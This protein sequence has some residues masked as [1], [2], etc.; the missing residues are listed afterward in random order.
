MISTSYIDQLIRDYAKSPA[1]K[2]EI[3]KQTGLIYV[4]KPSE[5][6]F[7]WYGEKMKSILYKYVS[8]LIKSVTPDDIIVGKPRQ[9]SDGRW[10]IDV[11]FKEDSLKRESLY[12]YEYPEGV[13]NIVLLF[14]KGYHARDYVYG[15]WNTTGNKNAHWIYKKDTRS[16][17][18]REGN[19]FLIQAVNEFN[20]M[21]NKNVATAEL[22]GKYKEC[23]ENPV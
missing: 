19:D 12:D 7:S 17:K 18:D 23:S 2:A 6:L 11:S 3:K 1:G 4:E 14:A 15:L 22:V 8:S 16:R 9:D 10:M 21:T 20:G 5:K 13:T